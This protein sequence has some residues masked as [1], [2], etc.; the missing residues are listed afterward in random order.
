MTLNRRS[1]IVCLFCRVTG[2]ERVVKT[3][4]HLLWV[5]WIIFVL[6]VL[7]WGLVSGRTFDSRQPLAVY[8]RPRSMFDNFITEVLS[9][10]LSLQIK[11]N[12]TCSSLI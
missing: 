12:D 2:P 10:Y 1:K 6:R 11:L 4:R 8:Q 9:N 7:T 5:L 3:A